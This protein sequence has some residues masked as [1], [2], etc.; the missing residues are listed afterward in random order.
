MRSEFH[1]KTKVPVTSSRLKCSFQKDKDGCNSQMDLLTKYVMVHVDEAQVHDF[2]FI[3][4]FEY[5][6]AVL[7]R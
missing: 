7:S 4:N 6:Y 2:A 1:S 5:M 3:F